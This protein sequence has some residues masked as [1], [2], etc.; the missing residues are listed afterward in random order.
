MLAV[1][2]VK[3][4]RII[5]DQLLTSSISSISIDFEDPKLTA[6]LRDG[7]RV[8]IQFNDH[9]Q[10]SYTIAFSSD[11]NDRCR[12]DN[13]DDRWRVDTK[14]NHFHPRGERKAIDSPMTGIPDHDTKLLC[15]LIL[16]KKLLQKEVHF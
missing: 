6:E 16:T 12:F 9:N 5:I 10:Y 2:L 11:Q 1:D 3:Q 8:Y 13:Y 14:P 15:D 4:A 7:T